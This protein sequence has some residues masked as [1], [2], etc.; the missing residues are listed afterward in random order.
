MIWTIKLSQVLVISVLSVYT[1]KIYAD[2]IKGR[3]RYS[4]REGQIVR[5][6]RNK[7]SVVT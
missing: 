1:I 4:Q 5:Q 3:K 6:Q 2:S 7:Q